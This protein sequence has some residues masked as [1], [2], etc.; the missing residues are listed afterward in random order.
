MKNKYTFVVAMA[1]AIA[2]AGAASASAQETRVRLDAKAEMRV[3]ANAARPAM[4]VSRE[5]KRDEVRPRI[6]ARRDLATSTRVRVEAKI[7]ARAPQVSDRL[8]AAVNKLAD[9]S[10]KISTRLDKIEDSGKDMTES[11]RLLANANTLIE[12][13]GVEARAVAAVEVSV[14]SVNESFEKLRNA[15]QDANKAIRSAHAAL[16]E[17]IV[18]IKAGLAP[19]VNATSSAQ[20]N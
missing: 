4:P 19:S 20:V 13:A 18:S 17:V 1:F 5:E 15:T 3:E 9:I 12:A 2:F 10:A 7:T 6:E 14:G 11:R 16:V 8:V